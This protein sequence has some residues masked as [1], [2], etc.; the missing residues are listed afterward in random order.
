VVVITR[1]RLPLL[2]ALWERLEA[3]EPPRPREVVVVLDGPD[4]ETRAWLAGVHPASTTGIGREAETGRSPRWFEQER[5]S[6]GGARNLGAREAAGEYV[7]FLDDDAVP[8][9]DLFRVLAEKL[10][11]HPDA[12]VLGGP[13]LTPPDSP[14]FERCVGYVLSSVWGAGRMSARY[15]SAGGDRPADDRSLIL[16]NLLVRRSLFA[17]GTA[18][19]DETFHYNEENLLLED[20]RRLGRRIVHCPDLVVQH[21]RR[22]TWAGYLVQVWNS[23]V[24]RGRMTVRRPFSFRPAFA[25][26]SALLAGAAA[27]PFVAGVWLRGPLAVYLAATAVHAALSLRAG[28][29]AA[30]AARVFALTVAGHL[31]YGAGFL[32][33]LLREAVP[34]GRAA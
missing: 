17:D 15:R 23:G 26:P 1:G 11:E 5:R 7:Y 4:P 33:G 30:G 10:R 8:P 34:S 3:C 18:R 19:F 2:R 29:S 20:L 31:A 12:D 25:A 9:P 16:C 14:P 32:A 28:F 22:G 27:A 13:N 6:K 24:G 21:R